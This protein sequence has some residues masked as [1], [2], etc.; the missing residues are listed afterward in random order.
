MTRKFLIQSHVLKKIGHAK[1]FKLK[2]VIHS[3]FKTYYSSHL[4][5]QCCE[6]A[7]KMSSW[8]E[9]NWKT[10]TFV[11]QRAHLQSRW[12]DDRKWNIRKPTD[13]PRKQINFPTEENQFLLLIYMAH[14]LM[15]FF[16]ASFLYAIPVAKN[17]INQLECSIV[18]TIGNTGFK[19]VAQRKPGFTQLQISTSLLLLVFTTACSENL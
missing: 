15:T 5:V 10:K 1:I 12:A 9:K 8:N 13:S 2:C 16:E 19:L 18:I 14:F 11:K 6:L 4:W 3:T 17:T 7:I